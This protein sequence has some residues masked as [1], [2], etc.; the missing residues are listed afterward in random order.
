MY[1]G[2]FFMNDISNND[3]FE[4]LRNKAVNPNEF[5]LGYPVNREHAFKID[6]ELLGLRADT[7]ATTY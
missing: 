1:D 3:I 7:L 5:A 2:E 4:C 6:L